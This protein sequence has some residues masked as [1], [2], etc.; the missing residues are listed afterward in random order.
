MAV[1]MVYPDG[2]GQQGRGKKG[3]LN[4]PFHKAYLSLARSVLRHSLPLAQSV[5]NGTTPLN[6]A[7]ATV[8]EQEQ[9][10]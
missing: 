7:L 9:Y 4:Q 5:L 2:Q 8:K 1:A 6:D 3:L 10:Q